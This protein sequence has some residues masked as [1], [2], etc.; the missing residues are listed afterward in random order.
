MKISTAAL[1]TLA[2]LTAQ[3]V[4]QNVT[5]ASA[6][7]GRRP[8]ASEAN[9]AAKGKR[10]VVS[11]APSAIAHPEILPVAQSS[12]VM[13]PT[14]APTAA[15]ATVTRSHPGPATPAQVQAYHPA[16][17][18]RLV[19]RR[20]FRNLA[21]PQV[22]AQAPR[23]PVHMAQGAAST[24]ISDR[25][26]VRGTEPNAEAWRAAVKQ[27]YGI[28]TV[29]T[30]ITDRFGARG[31]EPN[32]EAWRAAIKQRYGIR[33][34]PTPITDRF[35]ATGTEPNAE[36]WRAAIKQRYGIRIR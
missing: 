11:A 36:A 3:E 30:P 14:A 24:P 4:V 32:A 25:F 29:P 15:P 7:D 23:Q 10:V 6:H 17:G 5:I 28:P 26:G 12:P 8:Q 2:A 21:S 27:R 1:C 35:G 18:P 13:S 19:V 9:P 22:I 33:S 16:A 34:I 31:T 20:R